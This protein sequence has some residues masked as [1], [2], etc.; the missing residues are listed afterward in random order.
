M[1]GKTCKECP[2]EVDHDW[3]RA[4]CKECIN[5]HRRIRRA[6]IS[7]KRREKFLVKSAEEHRRI[8]EKYEARAGSGGV[9]GRRGVRVRLLDLKRLVWGK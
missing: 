3:Q 9:V 1:R 5:K 4:I 7:L 2:R 8:A 6:E